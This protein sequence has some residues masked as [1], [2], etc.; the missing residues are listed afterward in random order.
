[1][2][3]STYL[4]HQDIQTLLNRYEFKYILITSRYT[5][6]TKPI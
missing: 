1:M 5:N 4:L 6:I 3:L 2:N